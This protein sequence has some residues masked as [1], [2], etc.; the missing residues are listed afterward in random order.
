MKAISIYAF[1]ICFLSIKITRGNRT[2]LRQLPFIPKWQY[3]LPSCYT[4][5]HPSTLHSGL[6]HVES[7][8]D[9][10]K[11]V[12]I[13]INYNPVTIWEDQN[14]SDLSWHWMEGF[15]YKT[16]CLTTVSRVPMVW[17]QCFPFPRQ[18]ALP[19]LKSRLWY[20]L[21]ERRN[22]KP[23]FASFQGY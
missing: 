13:M 5:E 16:K 23:R 19:R 4:F 20:Y 2:I 18:V 21:F 14:R 8:S 9:R 10:R 7:L 3:H 11:L 12:T 22:K 17:I 15:Q 6:F 1:I